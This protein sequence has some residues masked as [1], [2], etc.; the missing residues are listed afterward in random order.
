MKLCK[1]IFLFSLLTLLLFSL[2]MGSVDAKPTVIKAPVILKINQYYILYTSP[3]VPYIDKQQRIMIPLR[4][5]SELLG[6]SVNYD[7]IKK[8]ASVSW[9]NKNI[10]VTINSNN[11]KYNGTN[12]KIDTVP[13]LKQKQVFIPAKVLLDG[14]NLKG[15]WEDQLL[16][17]K[18]SKFKKSKVISYLE[19]GYDSN[20]IPLNNDIDN[21]KIR[22]LS[23]E[24]TLPG[25]GSSSKIATLSVVARNI[26]GKDLKVGNEDLRPTFITDISYQYDKQDRDRS[27]VQEGAIFKRIWN[28]IDLSSTSSSN[29]FQYNPLKYIVA[30]GNTTD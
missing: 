26:S 13:V 17:I 18:D 1:N 5:V 8:I 9:D 14:L 30:V 11:V 25:V 3:D 10:E 19:G 12:T 21:N 29:N 15:S 16:T 4:A 7:A 20:T 6:A 24:L 23:Y 28:K 22:P 27:A 2:S